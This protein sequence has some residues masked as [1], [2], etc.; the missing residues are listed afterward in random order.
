MRDS[1]EGVADV[2][3]QRGVLSRVSVS[4]QLIYIGVQGESTTSRFGD[5]DLH[6]KASSESDPVSH[7]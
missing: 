4:L 3:S 1:R 6:P 7:I 2:C 5:F